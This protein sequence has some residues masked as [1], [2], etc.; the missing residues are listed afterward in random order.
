MK[1]QIYNPGQPQKKE[2]WD[3]SQDSLEEGIRERVLDLFT[4]GILL[5]SQLNGETVPFE[6]APDTGLL[7]RVGTGVA[8]APHDVSI[9]VQI[10]AADPTRV[11]A[12]RVFIP[13]A[14]TTTIPAND[15][16]NSIGA[17]PGTGTGTGPYTES[18]DGLGG[19]TATPQSTKTRHITVVNGAI[20][21]VWLAY[22]NTID[23]SVTSLHKINISNILYTK[24]EDGYWIVVNQSG[25]PP[26]GD[27]KYE[28]LGTVD[29]TASPPAV[30]GAQISMAGRRFALTRQQRVGARLDSA[31]LKP[32]TYV[33]PS[34]IGLEDHINAVGTGIV[35]PN[36]P[37]GMTL[38]DLGVTQDI[39]LRRHRIQDHSNGLVVPSEASTSS[40]IYPRTDTSTPTAGDAAMVF[41]KRFLTNET[42]LLDGTVYGDAD[43]DPLVKLASPVGSASTGDY[44][45]SF[46]V[47]HAAGVYGIVAKEVGSI[48]TI[49]KRSSPFTLDPNTDYLICYVEWNGTAFILPSAPNV[50]LDTRVF[51]TIGRKNVQK[52]AIESLQI[53]DL[54]VITSKIADQ[55]V[56]TP[57]I[58]DL[59]VTTNKIAALN[60]T[61][62]KIADAN[63]TTS[64]LDDAAVT[65]IKLAPADN[66]T[67]QVIG[68]GEGVKT[69]HIQDDAVISQH[70]AEWDGS[71]TA[72][73]PNTGSGVATAQ[74]KDGVI[75]TSKLDAAVLALVAGG[76]SPVG[77]ITAFGTGSAPPGWLQCDG[78][79]ISRTTYLTLFTVLGTVWGVGDGSTTF[80]LPDLR[81]RFAR[82]WNNGSGNDPNSGTRT[83]LHTG[84]ATADNVGSYQLDSLR[85]HTHLIWG[86]GAA[87]GGGPNSIYF[88]INSAYTS[89]SGGVSTTPNAETRPIN[90]YVMYI[91]RY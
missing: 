25:T 4:P 70:I 51:G 30:T 17:G 50:Q 64:K 22:L 52:D 18:P 34:D 8:T 41:L 6:I 9:P 88:G 86:V 81:G 39:D 72:A 15:Y 87:H 16:A 32:T 53:K 38:T 14:D 65:S 19:W 66:S 78:S 43:I 29:M 56:T 42:I 45:V 63:V 10:D 31:S 62:A 57:K 49:E 5:N 23:T 44:F 54:N 46:G 67:A 21:R 74:L 37:H 75:T 89:A 82:G 7:I 73:Q 79:A 35:S 36:N 61:T 83:A 55:N 60:V 28:F 90:V 47:S 11:G 68:V 58:A 12:E 27:L 71:S 84:G 2:S 40:A 26:G 91:I 24:S 85:D 80:N 20:N 33:D 48:V 69:G 1:G 3:H 13:T 76:A 59:N 77:S